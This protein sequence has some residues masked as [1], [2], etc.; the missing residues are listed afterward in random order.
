MI[1]VSGIALSVLAWRPNRNVPEAGSGT[2]S[3]PTLQVGDPVA[4]PQ[5]DCRGISSRG[6]VHYL[7][8]SLPSCATCAVKR[9]PK[10]LFTCKWKLPLVIVTQDD[11]KL[12]ISEMNV[13]SANIAFLFKYAKGNATSAGFI[14]Y[15]PREAEVVRDHVTAV[16][17][18]TVDLSGFL[19]PYRL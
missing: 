12:T 2:L 3:I 19:K 16:D 7:L 17:M 1:V 14:A 6:L 4:L 15:A 18:N 8:V 5:T 10:D 11:P 9:V 13:P